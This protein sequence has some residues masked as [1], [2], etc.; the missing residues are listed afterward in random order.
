MGVILI[1]DVSQEPRYRPGSLVANVASE[2]IMPLKA[3][4]Q[5]LGVFIV[6]SERVKGFTPGDTNLMH[7][8]ADQV[9]FAIY[10]S[11][12]LAELRARVQD[13]AVLT[14]ISLQVN[15][16]LD[17]GELAKHLRRLQRQSPDVFQLAVYNPGRRL[18]TS[19]A[20]SGGVQRNDLPLMPERDLLSRIVVEGTPVFWRNAAEREATL[21][22]YG[23]Q[24]DLPPSFL[25]IPM[26]VKDEVV[27][28]LC[29][30]SFQPNAFDEN[31]LQVMLTFANSAAVAVENVRLF[32]DTA[33][34][35]RELGAINEIS[36]TLVELWQRGH[37]GASTTSDAVHVVVLHRPDRERRELR[38]PWSRPGH[39]PSRAVSLAAL[40]SCHPARGQR[41]T[42][43]TWRLKPG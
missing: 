35:V 30:Q 21:S 32:Q 1:D 34:R 42:S 6:Q 23:L 15:T 40:A 33:R 18:C 9:A 4:G 31:D 37:V 13:I 24:G 43:V 11:R 38:L 14:E 17:L 29:S 39:A 27:G 8:I 3:A 10:N 2:L 36:H 7:S 5:I 16:T 12:L 20:M 26:M 28:V 19:K 25:G 22:F 41:F